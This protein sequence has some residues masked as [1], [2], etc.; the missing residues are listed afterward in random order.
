MKKYMLSLL[1]A[2]LGL[3]VGSAYGNITGVNVQS[4]NLPATG[5]KQDT[6]DFIVEFNSNNQSLND[7]TLKNKKIKKVK[8]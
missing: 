1:L 3:V 4:C 5:G 7:L 6:C 2:T 8:S